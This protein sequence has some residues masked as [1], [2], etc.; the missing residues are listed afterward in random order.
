VASPV[1]GTKAGAKLAFS[2]AAAT[3]KA[4]AATAKAAATE[5]TTERKRIDK[6]KQTSKA[7]TYRRAPSS[8]PRPP[9]P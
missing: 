3:A 9:P 4:A 2:K 1:D 8:K 5:P 6:R 7:H